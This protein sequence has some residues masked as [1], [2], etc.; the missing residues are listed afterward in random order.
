M[1]LKFETPNF[2]H[3][4]QYHL[5]WFGL[6]YFR[7]NRGLLYLKKNLFLNFLSNKSEIKWLLSLQILKIQKNE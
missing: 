7:E 1:N 6:D 4:L 5:S 2:F 3:V